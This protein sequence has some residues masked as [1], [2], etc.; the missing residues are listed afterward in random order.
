MPTPAPDV[1]V[2]LPGSVR[3]LL[4]EES[5]A[6]DHAGIWRKIEAAP[7]HRRGFGTQCSVELS[8]AEASTLA[9]Y[10]WGVA[11]L[12][13]SMTASERGGSDTRSLWRVVR[14]VKAKLEEG[15]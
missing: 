10:L 5:F 6:D 14:Q 11:S 2:A 13:D 8:R 7:T 15:Q 1:S 9:D 4:G 12:E 3:R